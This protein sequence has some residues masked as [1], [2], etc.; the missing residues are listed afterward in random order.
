MSD[1][2]GALQKPPVSFTRNAVFY[3]PPKMEFQGIIYALSVNYDMHLGPPTSNGSLPQP[4]M[5]MV[6]WE[7]IPQPLWFVR[8]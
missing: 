1:N 5:F 6:N 3:G 7:Q 2:G 8:P 4:R